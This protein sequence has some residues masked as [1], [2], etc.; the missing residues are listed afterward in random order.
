MDSDHHPL[1][2]DWTL[3]APGQTNLHVTIPR[4][5]DEFRDQVAENQYM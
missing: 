4:V 2:D 1:G 3:W 5:L